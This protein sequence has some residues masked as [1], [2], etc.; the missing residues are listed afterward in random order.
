MKIERGMYKDCLE[1]IPAIEAKLKKFAD[2][3]EP[4][5]QINLFYLFAYAYF[6]TSQHRKALLIANHNINN[7]EENDKE[8]IYNLSKVFLLILHCEL[9]HSDLLKYLIP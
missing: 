9:N 3:I 7:Y 1:I 4:A 6:K 5:I 8:D 2:R